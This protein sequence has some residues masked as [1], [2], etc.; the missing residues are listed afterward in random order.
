MFGPV[1]RMTAFASRRFVDK[2][3]GQPPP[4]IANDFSTAC[5][6]FGSGVVARITCGLVAPQD[7]TN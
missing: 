5:L 4:E 1:E 6:E 7:R 2:R 3:T